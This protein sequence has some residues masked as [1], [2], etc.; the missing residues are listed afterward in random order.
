MAA[1]SAA[2]RP[3]VHG[4][5]LKKFLRVKCRQFLGAKATPTAIAENLK[6][7]Y[8]VRYRRMSTLPFSLGSYGNV[9]AL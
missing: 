4:I 8:A 9:Y 7:N 6:G 1:S 5:V 2:A 3:P